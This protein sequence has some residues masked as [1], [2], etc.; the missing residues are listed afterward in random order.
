[1]LM[2]TIGHP[3]SDFPDIPFEYTA[4]LCSRGIVSTT[5]M[6]EEADSEEKITFLSAETGIPDYRLRELFRLCELCKD[7]NVDPLQARKLFNQDQ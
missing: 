6:L 3:L 1:M 7:R 4:S 5:D 2:E